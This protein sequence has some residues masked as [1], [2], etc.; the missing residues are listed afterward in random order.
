MPRERIGEILEADRSVAGS[1]QV[2]QAL[3]EGEY[4]RCDVLAKEDYSAPLVPE[5][6]LLIQERQH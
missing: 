5:C 1:A 2:N 3:C 4:V 6:A